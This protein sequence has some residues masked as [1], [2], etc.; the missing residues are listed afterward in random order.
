MSKIKLKIELSLSFYNGVHIGGGKGSG[1]IDSLVL[2]DYKGNPYIP[3]SSLKG[4][5]RYNYALLINSFSGI[6]T[7]CGF[8][9]ASNKNVLSCNCDVC[10]L[11][12]GRGNNP[13]MLYFQ[14][15]KLKDS[16]TNKN[17]LYSV[18]TGI[19]IDRFSNVVKDK[20]LFTLE[21]SGISEN[22][23][24]VG[25]IEGYIDE[26]DYKQQII[27]LY[28]AIKMI[29]SLGGNQSR[30]FG[31][32]S[33]NSTVKIFVDDKLIDDSTLEKWGECIEI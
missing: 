15:L 29:E 31:W 30:G 21:T 14:D 17:A 12:G 32:I 22:N 27:L 5:I 16:N 10:K 25:F 19:Q 26:K 33:N 1:F 4:R 13:G 28:T 8:T 6:G 18:R 9:G 24:F 2:K 7:L 23:P 20:A 3:G 11:F